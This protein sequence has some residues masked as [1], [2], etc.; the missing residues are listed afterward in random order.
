MENFR[1]WPDELVERAKTLWDDG[2]SAGTIA[3]ALGMT[4]NAV[5]GKAH[6]ENW[7]TRRPRKNDNDLS[8]KQR[9]QERY[10]QNRARKLQQRA[11]TRLA[12][13]PGIS[14]DV[15]DGPPKARKRRS[16]KPVSIF[17]LRAHHC[18]WPLWDHDAKMCGKYC[19]R[20][21]KT[22]PY[23]AEHARIAFQ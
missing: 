23:C 13:M 14:A 7:E 12:P 19:G 15:L 11:R 10:D 3:L 4:R 2:K 20:K 5:I 16:G 22:G 9:R 8:W 17:A 1:K 18:R 6:R 21:A